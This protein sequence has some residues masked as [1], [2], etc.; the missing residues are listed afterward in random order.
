[1]DSQHGKGY[2]IF[3]FFLSLFH[4]LTNSCDPPALKASRCGRVFCTTDGAG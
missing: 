1:M 3:F 4:K 2:F